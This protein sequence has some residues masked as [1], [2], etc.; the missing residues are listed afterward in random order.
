MTTPEASMLSTDPTEVAARVAD[1]FPA[2]TDRGRTVALETYRAL[3]LGMPVPIY[4]IAA[5]TRLT[6]P[7]V[8][9]EMEGWPGIQTSESGRIDGFWGLTLNETRHSFTINDVQLFTWCAWDTLFLP[10][11]LGG[12]AQVASES[13]AS[14]AAISVDVGPEGP[15]ADPPSAVVSFVDP[16]AG[17]V[18]GEDIIS[19]FCCHVLFFPDRAEGEAWATDAGNGTR[20]LSIDEAFEIGQAF[21]EMRFGE[22][23]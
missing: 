22:Q 20:I 11:L 17:S 5:A 13:P 16:G 9:Q 6:I 2:L 18:D 12:R 4:A 1:T 21:N 7:E 19:T 14:G 15:V 23:L 8:T 10:G 3:A